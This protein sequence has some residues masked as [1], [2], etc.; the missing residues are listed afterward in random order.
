MEFSRQEYWSGLPFPSPGDLPN[1]EV[2]SNSCLLSQWCYLTIL[3]S[4]AHFS[5][6]PQSFSAQVS[7]FPM[8]WLF[9]SG[10]QSIGAS[11]S[12]S[13]LPMNIQHWFS[14]GLIIPW[15]GWLTQQNCIF[16]QLWRLEAW[17]PV[18][19]RV[20]S[21]KSYKEESMPCLSPSFWW[22]DGN[23]SGDIE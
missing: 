5:S 16:S 7:S 6:C 17:D 18:V 21:S 19:R 15:P 3:S 12:A 9:T 22:F 11:A 20:G 8:S 23:P 2:C 13:V 10:G 1:P 14:L 4:V